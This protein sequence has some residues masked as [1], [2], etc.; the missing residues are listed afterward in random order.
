MPNNSKVFCLDEPSGGGAYYVYEIGNSGGVIPPDA[1][2]I[3]GK[4]YV[5]NGP[6]REVG[7]NGCHQ[8]DLLIIV[9]D[10]LQHFQKGE[11][12]CRENDLALQKIEEALHWLRHRTNGRIARNVEG[13]HKH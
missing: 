2:A 6:V 12:A 5:Q 9:I 3:F 11:F 7:I 1:S 8:E 10:R 4:V 13:T